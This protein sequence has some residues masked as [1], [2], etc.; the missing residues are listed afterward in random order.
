MLRHQDTVEEN[1]WT[2]VGVNGGMDDAIPK[3][4]E[5]LNQAQQIVDRVEPEQLDLPSTCSDWTVR[6]LINHLVSANLTVAA[7]I[8]GDPRPAPQADVL[9]NDFRNAFRAAADEVL[10]AFQSEE[11]LSRMYQTPIGEVPG[12]VLAGMRMSECVAHSWDLAKS[13]GQDTALDA[14]LSNEALRIYMSG[15]QGRDRTGGAFGPEQ[16]APESAS[17][18]EKLAA[19]LGRSL[20]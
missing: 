8:L 17:P 3:L 18:A 7:N 6:Q 15:L 14:E 5:A 2:G 1:P 11:A 19:Y 9:G 12:T 13:T 16:P 4:R 20:E 10:N